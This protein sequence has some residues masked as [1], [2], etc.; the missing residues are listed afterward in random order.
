[1]APTT[2]EP[3]WRQNATVRLPQS[4]GT[5]PNF[6]LNQ[7]RA[8]VSC[9]SK[10]LSLLGKKMPIEFVVVGRSTI[11]FMRAFFPLWTAPPTQI[12][13]K[14]HKSLLDQHALKW[15]SG[16]KLYKIQ[17][18]TRGSLAA[19]VSNINAVRNKAFYYTK[20]TVACR[21]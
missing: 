3:S 15:S 1:M 8:R 6:S 19:S 9:I 4:H 17:N 13:L 12:I 21:T 2:R 16:V 14:K 10:L 7:T 11:L 5:W 20:T 18:Q